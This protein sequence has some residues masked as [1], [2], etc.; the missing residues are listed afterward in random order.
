MEGAGGAEAA[1]GFGAAEPGGVTGAD[2]G[3]VPGCD[4]LQREDLWVLGSRGR[5]AWSL[6]PA[7]L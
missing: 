5:S 1:A 4:L 6:Y 3:A 2:S 7:P